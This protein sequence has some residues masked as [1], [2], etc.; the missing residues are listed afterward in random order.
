MIIVNEIRLNKI[1]FIMP[2]HISEGR[3]GG[4]EVQAWLLA[5]ELAKRG[6]QVSY[7]AE[8]VTG[9]AGKVEQRDGVEIHWLKHYL[10]FRWR[11]AFAY[12]QAIKRV[13]PD[14]LVQ[15]MSSYVTGIVGLYAHRHHKPFAW[16]CTDNSLPVKWVFAKKQKID[17][18]KK[19]HS[20]IKRNVL[21]ADA[22]LNDMFRQLGMKYIT[23]PFT[24]NEAQYQQ[25]KNDF[26]IESFHLGSGHELP[27]TL[28]SCK[29]R[30]ENKMV[31]WVATMGPR[32]RPW[33]F[34]ELARMCQDKDW[35]F[36]MVGGH[37]DQKYLDSF[38][39]DAPANLLLTGRLPFKEALSWSDKATVFVNTSTAEGEG[40]PNTFI[41]SWLHG[42]PVIS[43]TVDPDDI[44]KKNNLGYV[45]NGDLQQVKADLD[46]LLTN[47]L[48]Y[49]QHSERVV[50]F[51]QNHYTIDKVADQFL[52]VITNHHITKVKRPIE[53]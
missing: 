34:V 3:G 51:A 6:Y 50:A 37:S 13:N 45:A 18:Q 38:L 32:K 29:T 7:I 42:V 35:Q 43:L 15:R 11:N 36:V 2:F 22:L 26:G 23:Y 17:S 9:N 53:V 24:Q 12:Y 41:Q 4:A 8:S 40:F 5:K 1:C 20:F 10:H 16:I 31:L 19:S 27:K 30:F 49:E 46:R 33:K 39:K 44:I 52:N 48:T 14:L 28:P 47:E 25:L 21:V